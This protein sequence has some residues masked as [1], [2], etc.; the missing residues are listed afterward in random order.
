MDFDNNIICVGRNE[1]ITVFKYS[2]E[3]FE[4]F[5]YK[6]WIFRIVPEDLQFIDWFEFSVAEIGDDTGKV[7]TMNNNNQKGYSA[8][9]IPDKMIEEA[10]KKLNLNIISSSNKKGGKFFDNEWRTTDATKVWN[11]LVQNGLANYNYELDFYT[12]SISRLKSVI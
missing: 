8:K 5:G 1:V 9:G 6:K 4:T 11:R 12:Y 10:S 3:E 2:L 7:I